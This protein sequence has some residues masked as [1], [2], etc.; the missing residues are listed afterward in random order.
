MSYTERFTEVHALLAHIPALLVNAIA[1]EHNTGWLDVSTCHRAVVLIN[2]GEWAG[3]GTETIDMDVEEALD[4]NG[5]GAR[6]LKS[7]TQITTADSG[8]HPVAVEVRG[9]EMTP[10]YGYINVEVT[11][12]GLLKTYYFY[13]VLVFGTVPRYVAVPIALWG[14]IV[15]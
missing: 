9:E 5:T 14:E 13:D 15:P 4:T 11:V 10:G 8:T 12:G 3:I 6:T 2:P 1:G 7:I